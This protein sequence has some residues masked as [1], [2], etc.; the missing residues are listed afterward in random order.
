MQ[1]D[2]KIP[3]FEE[4]ER[5]CDFIDSRIIAVFTIFQGELLGK[6]LIDRFLAKC[7]L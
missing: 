4:A 3:V 6:S 7:K 5:T 2:R 1:Q